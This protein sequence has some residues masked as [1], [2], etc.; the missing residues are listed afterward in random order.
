MARRAGGRARD[1]QARRVALVHDDGALGQRGADRGRQRLRGER[2]GRAGPAGPT[3]RRG[4]AAAGAPTASA[5][6]SRAPAASSPRS[7]SVCT[8][9]PGGH[10]VARLVGVGEEGDRGG[11]VDQDE[12]PHAV[13]L[14]LGDLG[15]VAEPLDG[16][17]AR[18]A[19]EVGREGLAEQAAPGGRRP[20]WPPAGRGPQRAAT[21][22]EGRWL[23][24]AQRLGRRLDRVGRHHGAVGPRGRGGQGPSADSDHDA[25]AGR[26]SVA[27]PPGGP[28]AAATAS[29]AS[30]ATSSARAVDRY[31]PETAPARDAM[32]DWSGAS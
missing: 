2:A 30:P 9:Q 21:E 27:T 1:E 3:A 10:E 28:S 12:V 19:F 15:Q 24:R 18:P 32:S 7:A 29:A 14:G 25:S 22:E 11:G 6:A 31:Q 23:A 20:G 13:E 26:T 17:D 8:V 16:R 5:S 4:G